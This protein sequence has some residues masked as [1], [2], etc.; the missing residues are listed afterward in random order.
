M[1]SPR[2]TL[3]DSYQPP[4]FDL[5]W[6]I[7]FNTTVPT[8]NTPVGKRS[9]WHLRQDIFNG[10]LLEGATLVD[11]YGIPLIQPCSA[12]P[13]HLIAF[14]EAKALTTPNADA[15]VH[16]YEHDLRFE[17]LWKQ[18]ERWLE[19]LRGF[20]GV[21]SPDF[22]V[23]RNM[24]LADQITYTYRNQLLGS[25]LQRNG[26]PVIANVRLSGP[27]S[28]PFAIAGSPREATIAIGL[29]G[30]TK[31][32]DNRRHVIEEV[33]MICHELSPTSIV[34]YGGASYG[35]L[36]YPLELNIPVHIFPPDTFVR[37]QHRK[38]AA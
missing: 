33:R 6:Q 34:A 23:Y 15:W 5:H 29:H 14:S 19:R 37:S 10:R 30:C 28:I 27:K 16:F 2:V 17:S 1:T 4:L 11:P 21:V 8:A 35:V 22:S 9:D 7:S 31:N 20:A 18:P 3:G 25:W 38:A 36:D 13:G 32:L 24:T 26:L 12:V